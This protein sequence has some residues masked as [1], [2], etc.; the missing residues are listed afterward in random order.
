MYKNILISKLHELNNTTV[1]EGLNGTLCYDVSY[2]IMT[3]R[4]GPQHK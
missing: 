4:T 2:D 3:Q 1:E